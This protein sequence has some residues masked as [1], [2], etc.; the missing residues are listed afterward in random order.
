MSHIAG[1]FLLPKGMKL[2]A[3][4]SVHE[5]FNPEGAMTIS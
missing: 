4:A 1:K 3:D 2:Y 5:S